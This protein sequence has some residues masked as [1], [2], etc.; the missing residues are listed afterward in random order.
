VTEIGKHIDAYKLSFFMYKDKDSNG[1]KLHFG[2]I[3]DFNLGFGN[4]DFACPPQPQGWAFQFRDFCEP[5]HPF[6]VEKLTEIPQVSHQIN[7]RWAEL[8]T[9]AWHTDSLMQLIDENVEALNDAQARNFER[10]Q[11]LGVYVWPNDFVGQTYEEEV[12]FLKNWLT[13]RLDWM[14]ANMLGNCDFFVANDNILPVQN[15]SIYPNPID[16]YLFIKL[17]NN[18]FKNTQFELYDITGKHIHTYY[19]SKLFNKIN[20][21]NIPKGIYTYSVTQDNMRIKIGKIIKE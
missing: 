21:Q 7:C 19:I 3:W 5:Y 2:P 12:D 15:I 10:W 1:G 13:Q 16:N 8:R 11:V 4:F 6:W 20:L 17:E 14:D 18:N 9:R